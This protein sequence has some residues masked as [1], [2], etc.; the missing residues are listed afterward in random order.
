M[1]T[2]V[3]VAFVPAGEVPVGV[4]S[5]GVVVGDVSSAVAKSP[6]MVEQSATQAERPSVVGTEG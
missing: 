1:A 2:G 4:E 6:A 3:V 5:E